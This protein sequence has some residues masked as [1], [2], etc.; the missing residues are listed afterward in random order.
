MEKRRSVPLSRHSAVPA[1]PHM[2]GITHFRIA[3]HMPNPALSLMSQHKGAYVDD[4]GF[5]PLPRS[6][7][8]VIKRGCGIGL[9]ILSWVGRRGVG[10]AIILREARPEAKGRIDGNE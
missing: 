5:P 7:R 3:K 1:T 2:T 6:H 8:N 10:E 9:A 4:S